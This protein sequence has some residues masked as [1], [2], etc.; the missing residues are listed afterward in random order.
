[1]NEREEEEKEEDEEEE[2]RYYP[3]TIYVRCNSK[4]VTNTTFCQ[5]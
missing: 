2:A 4:N 3:S 1:M 5:P